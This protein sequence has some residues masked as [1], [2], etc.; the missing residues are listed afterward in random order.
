MQADIE[1]R[2]LA[3]YL[4]G[5][6]RHE[7]VGNVTNKCRLDLLL[8][9]PETAYFDDMADFEILKARVLEDRELIDK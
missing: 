5:H 3:F 2:N 1:I 9:S 4:H 8:V 7:L 6:A